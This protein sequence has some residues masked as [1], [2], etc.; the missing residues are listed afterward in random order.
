M[1]G[2]LS[3]QAPTLEKLEEILFANYS[4]LILD[5]QY[6]MIDIKKFET[7][8]EGVLLK[9]TFLGLPPKKEDSK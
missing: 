9:L 3:I 4:D 7:N 2:N 5:E 6:S 1:G 8:L